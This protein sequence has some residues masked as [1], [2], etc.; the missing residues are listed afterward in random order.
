VVGN[1]GGGEQRGLCA[2]PGN[3]RFSLADQ[4]R[5]RLER[6]CRRLDGSRGL[7]V[8]LAEGKVPELVLHVL[9]RT[10]TVADAEALEPLA[11][12]PRRYRRRSPL[13]SLSS[14]P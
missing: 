5:R 6:M 13:V 10:M 1:I 12:E 8:E 11:A 2:Q 7:I 9:E 3:G 4:A 14:R